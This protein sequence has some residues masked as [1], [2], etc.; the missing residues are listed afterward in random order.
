MRWQRDDAAA[1]AIRR[2]RSAGLRIFVGSGNCSACHVGPHFTNG[3][4]HDIGVPFFVGTGAST[5]GRHGG[6]RS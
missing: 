4:F 5:P 6:I 3:E 2:R 1:R